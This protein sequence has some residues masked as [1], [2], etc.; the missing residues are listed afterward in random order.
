MKVIFFTHPKECQSVRDAG[1]VEGE[2]FEGTGVIAPGKEDVVLLGGVRH[3]V[4]EVQWTYTN[5]GLGNAGYGRS[6][7]A[8]YLWRTA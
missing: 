3:V 7:A 1:W 4:R 2:S 8:V 5:A 6:S